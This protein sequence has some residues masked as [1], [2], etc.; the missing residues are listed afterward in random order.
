MGAD[1]SVSERVTNSACRTDGQGPWGRV[2]P[3]HGR[4]RAV[5]G[6]RI[7]LCYRKSFTLE[8][9]VTIR[10]RYTVVGRKRCRPRA[11]WWTSVTHAGLEVRIT[12][13]T[14]ANYGAPPLAPPP[15]GCRSWCPPRKA[16]GG[17]SWTTSPRS[18]AAA[19][20]L[21]ARTV[22]SSGGV[23]FPCVVT[24]WGSAGRLIRGIA[25]AS[26]PRGNTLVAVARRRAAPR[27][28]P[29][30]NIQGSG[31]SDSHRRHRD[32]A[33]T[34]PSPRS[35]AAPSTAAVFGSR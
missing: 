35:T 11:E 18:A 10:I 4:L 6:R 33:S 2:L 25:P 15:P 28:Y 22:P 32:P 29:T 3:T 30:V 27:A 9:G 14:T 5:G 21:R 16:A 34:R 13:T 1:C 7:C 19:L 31:G 12:T 17:G 24:G 20:E 23:R 26:A 8:S